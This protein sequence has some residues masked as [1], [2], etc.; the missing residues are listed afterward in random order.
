MHKCE[1]I[2][3]SYSIYV[4]QIPYSRKFGSDFNLADLVVQNKT[5]NI[6]T[7]NNNATA[8]LITCDISLGG[9]SIS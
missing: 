7:V 9:I 2:I 4:Y 5:A 3:I 8:G 1:I 6:I